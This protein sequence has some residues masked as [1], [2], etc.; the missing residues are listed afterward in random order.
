M[1]RLLHDLAIALAGVFSKLMPDKI[2]VTIIGPEASREL[3]ESIAHICS[4]KVLVVTDTTLVEIG[5]IDRMT[6]SLAA[7][8]LGWSVYSG[9]EPDPTFA[10]VEAAFRSSSR[11]IERGWS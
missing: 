10:Q 5:L 7:V 2:P 6:D 9:V 11:W 1:K 3:C 4:E 8:G